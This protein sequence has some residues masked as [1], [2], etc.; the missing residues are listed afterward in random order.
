MEQHNA[1]VLTWCD[2]I[3]ALLEDEYRNSLPHFNQTVPELDD[4][5]EY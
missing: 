3:T 1:H 5:S 2:Y 4:I